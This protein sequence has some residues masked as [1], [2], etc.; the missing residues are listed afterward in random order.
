MMIGR[1]DGAHLGELAFLELPKEQLYYGPMQIESRINQD[2]NISKDLNL[3]NQQGSRVLRG[4]MTVL[5]VD[6][7]FLFAQPIYLQA[8]QARMPQLKKVVI[9]VGNR[10]IYTDTYEQALAELN[11]ATPA[12]T[13]DSRQPAAPPGAQPAPNEANDPRTR[14]QTLRQRMDRYRQLTAQGKWAEA[15]RELEAIES[16]LRK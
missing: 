5:P 3:W 8:N 4:Q 14:L 10:L 11:A 7:K 6:N 9:A 15:G 12:P 1:G 16:E 13:T 2:Q